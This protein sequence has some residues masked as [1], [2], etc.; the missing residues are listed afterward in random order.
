MM[1]DAWNPVVGGGQVHI[2]KV[3]ERLI[4]THDCAID[5]F[6]R[7]LKGADGKHWSDDESHFGGKLTVHR[8]G[9]CTAFHAPWGRLA[10][11][12]TVVPAVVK[13]HK[14]NPY[15]LIHAHAFLAAIP[16]KRLQRLLRL[17]L[18][19][20]VHGT[21]LFHKKRGLAAWVE[22]QL[23]CRWK[24]DAEISAAHNFTRLKNRN[25]NIVVIPNG[26]EVAPFDAVKETPRKK[27]TLL[28]V[29]RFD[30]IKGHATLLKAMESLPKDI[31]CE[32]VGDGEMETSLRR[33]VLEK[34]MANIKFLGRVE[35]N[36]LIEAYKAADAIVLP[37]LSEGQPLVL[38]EAWAAKK[39]VV[40]THVGDNA[41]MVKDGV[42]GFLAKPADAED[43]AKKIMLLYRATPEARRAMGQRGYEG[44]KKDF[45]WEKTAQSVYDVYARLT[46]LL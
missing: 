6:V 14:K 21:S 31:E 36:N 3:A 29:A 8:V 16:A 13:R 2:M 30:P 28:C 15:H 37:S 1:V 18:I 41:R 44:V 12:F 32:L 34:Q 19:F 25:K 35:G 45:T 4:R 42:N 40:V 26:V 9:P 17:P 33:W 38:L 43:L 20:S 46:S 39:P 27:F 24:Y 22:R 11:L 5:L 7:A 10:W 23:L